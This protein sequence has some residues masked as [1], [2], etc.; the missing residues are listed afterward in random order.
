MTETRAMAGMTRNHYKLLSSFNRI[1]LLLIILLMTT[2]LEHVKDQ[3]LTVLRKHSRFG[4]ER[5]NEEAGEGKERGKANMSTVCWRCY[6]S[7][8]SQWK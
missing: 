6:V 3:L 4:A 5:G 7:S 8:P 1:L 2:V